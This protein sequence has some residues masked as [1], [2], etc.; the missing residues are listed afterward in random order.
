MI[1]EDEPSLAAVLGATLGE[2]QYDNFV[3]WSASRVRSDHLAQFHTKFWGK[4]M[5]EE[6]EEWRNA[7]PPPL[8]G[9]EGHDRDDKMD[10]DRDGDAG[11]DEDEGMD[12]GD[13]DNDVIPGCYM[14]DISIEGL[15]ISKMWIRAEYIQIFDY[16]EAFF[17]K[18]GFPPGRPPSAVITGQPGIGVF[19]LVVSSI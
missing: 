10:G 6:E 16:I 14:L 1:M 18:P 7:Q 12:Q 4:S 11:M 9:D 15:E 5:E 13:K 17:K 2:D 19:S 3:Q 8:T